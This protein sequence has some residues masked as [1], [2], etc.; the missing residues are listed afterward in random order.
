MKNFRSLL[1]TTISLVVSLLFL[2]AG[3]LADHRDTSSSEI[4]SITQ[5]LY[6]GADLFRILSATSPEQIPVAVGQVFGTIQQTNFLQRAESIAESIKDKKPDVIGLQE[7]SLL[8]VQSPSDYFMGN[9]DA[10]RMIVY[11]Y[12]QI[13]LAALESRDLHYRVAAQVQNVDVE[14]PALVG[15]DPGTGTPLFNDVRLTDRDVILVREKIKSADAVGV[16]FQTNLV[17][18]V[19]GIPITFTRGYTG[20]DVTV[21]DKTYRVV[22]THLEVKGEGQVP[23]IQML[24]AQELT[25]VLATETRPIVLLGDLN[26]PDDDVIDPVTGFVPPILQFQWAGFTDAWVLGGEDDGGLTCCQSETLNNAD[27]AYY[28]RIDYVLYRPDSR[29]LYMQGIKVS[30]DTFGDENEDKTVAGLWPADHAGVF[31]RIKSKVKRRHHPERRFA[32][33][34]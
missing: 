33:L 27:S 1:I 14:L 32:Q 6:V 11:D 2:P 21:H 30:A 16:N 10:A 24:Q 28:E 12:L 5:N 4:K 20:V 26:S 15:F 25:A 22:N 7:V 3:A 8:R 31:A 17:V 34:H 29:S 19:A 9:P 13:L 23:F 18:P